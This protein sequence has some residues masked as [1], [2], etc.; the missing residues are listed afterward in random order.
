[1]PIW[2]GADYNPEQW[3]E[4]I[5]SEDVALMRS[6]SINLATVGVFSWARMEPRDGEYD[7]AWLDTVIDL[8]HAGGVRIDL[9]TAT[10]SPPPWLTTAHPEVLPVTASGVRLSQG[11]RQHYCPSSPVYRAHA[12]RLVGMLAR[13]YGQH[14][15]LELWHVNNEYGSH[16]SRCYC[17][18]SAN[19]FRVWLRTK[20]STIDA[21]NLAWGTEFWSQQY[22]SLEEI[23]PPR[24]APTFTNPTQLLDFDRF[25][26]DEFLA[27]YQAEVVILRQTGGGVPVTT[28]FMGFFKPVD[29][30]KW[31]RE[32]DVVTDDSYP[33]P[34]DPDSPVSAAMSRDLMRSLG[35]GAPWILMEQAP[36]AVNWRGRN[37]PK[38]PGQMRA[39][40]YQA[41]A[42]GADGILF[43]QWRQSAAGA[44]QFHSGM[45][46]HGGTDTRI[47]HEVEQLG[48]ELAALSERVGEQ[49]IVGARVGAGVAIVLDWDSWWAL[50]QDAKPAD[51]D[52][53]QQIFAWYREF[54]D[55]GVAV[56]FV[57]ASDELSMYG[58][59]LVPSLF[60]ATDEQ[61]ANLDGYARDGGTLLVTYQ[62]AITDVNLRARMG[63][64]LGVLQRTLGVWV[65]EFAPLVGR[66]D[67]D[68]PPTI[69]VAGEVFG[70]KAVGTLWSE[71]VRVTNATVM[72]EFTADTLAGWPAVTQNAVG[73]G[74]AWYVATLPEPGA[75]SALVGAVLADG[76]IEAEPA[77]GGERGVEVVRRGGLTFVINHC[78]LAV[79]VE[80]DGTDLLSGTP[81]RDM[82]LVSQGVAIISDYTG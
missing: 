78:A 33:D 69:P 38:A 27:C 18:V 70:G 23:L 49:A 5:W 22:G 13:R 31:A 55:R 56:E 15:A 58:L 51:L 14:P 1:M 3:P 34:A 67:A 41:L 81:A 61:L 40:S 48:A 62:S 60:V 24:A 47:W 21:L 77:F 54:W 25:S 46:P 2:Y 71:F 74:S 32:V 79:A 8:L 30:W 44:E 72:A 9:A 39:W 45:V 35:G 57:R 68:K 63:G 50:E 17:D 29:Y 6:G 59:V 11:S 66:S 19:A 73:S 16:L 82:Q 43:F 7:F 80:L 65:E 75:L 10:A 26:S 64:Y 37:A 4:D 42:R 12:A 28:N 20:Y 52:Y 36:S 53:V 76:G